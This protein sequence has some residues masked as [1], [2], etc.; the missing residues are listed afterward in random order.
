M[1]ADS[2]SGRDAPRF[3]RSGERRVRLAGAFGIAACLA[4]ALTG[5]AAA[6]EDPRP[7]AGLQDNSF[8]I[9][10]AYNQE[11]GTAQHVLQMRRQGRDWFLGFTQEWALGNQLHQLSYT[12]P[13]AWL[14][15]WLR[16]GGQRAAGPGDAMF[17]YR[18][19][20]LFETAALPAVAP[21]LSLIV[22][23]G[24]AATGLGEGSAGLQFNLPVSKIV[25]DRVTLHFNAGMTSYFDVRGRQPTSFNVGGSAVYA[26]TRD[27]TLALETLAEWNAT[28]TETRTIQRDFSVTVSTGLRY[29]FNLEAGQLVVGAAVPVRL[30]QDR[31][32]YGLIGYLSFE[33]S[34]LKPAGR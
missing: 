4:G 29:A 20:L 14:N 11:R 2:R 10:E 1:L 3:R 28:V 27:F 33:H 17:D 25:A 26:F 24:R 8:L 32:S 12:L 15:P 22:P 34:L 18:Y 5:P 9:E 6:Q 19:Q 7:A 13:Y 30:S 23:T 21:R 16:S 31:P